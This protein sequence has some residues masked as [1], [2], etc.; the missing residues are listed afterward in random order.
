[1]VATVQCNA[2]LPL[3]DTIAALFIIDLPLSYIASLDLIYDTAAA[4]DC[5]DT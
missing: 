5:N 3:A 1:M 2:R 4:S